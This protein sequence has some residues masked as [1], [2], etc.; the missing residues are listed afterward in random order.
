MTSFREGGHFTHYV[1]P[2]QDST[3]F[4]AFLVDSYITLLLE[5]PLVSAKTE[6]RNNFRYHNYCKATLVDIM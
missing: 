1:T 6:I 3:E 5:T 2:I 4:G